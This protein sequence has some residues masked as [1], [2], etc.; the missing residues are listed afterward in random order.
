[1]GYIHYRKGV[2]HH[3]HLRHTL[4]AA[5]E[6]GA[7]RRAD[8]EY[9]NR[10]LAHTGARPLHGVTVVPSHVAVEVVGSAAVIK[11]PPIG[12]RLQIVEAEKTVT[13]R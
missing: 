7:L 2:N 9:G 13:H 6:A 10:Y 3:R 8:W 1:M 4:A 11:C 5:D 12:H